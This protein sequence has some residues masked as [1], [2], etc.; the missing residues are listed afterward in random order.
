MSATTEAEFST[1][2]SKA[3]AGQL[4]VD[5][6]HKAIPADPL[7]ARLGVYASLPGIRSSTGLW[8]N[9]QNGAALQYEVQDSGRRYRD[10]VVRFTETG[11]LQRTRRPAAADDQDNPAT[12]TDKSSGFW[13]YAQ[14]PD[15]EPVLD[16]LGL[17]YAVAGGP[18]AK[19]GDHM[20]VLV[21]Q[22]RQLVRVKLVVDRLIDTP[23]SFRATYPAG[24][25]TCSGTSRALRIRLTVAPFGT[26]STDFDFLGLKRRHRRAR[27]NRRVG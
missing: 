10:R 4:V 8:M 1:A 3:I 6:A 9:A 11:A 5:P 14:S 2:A 17:L 20:D 23:V 27:W 7:V 21:F 25:R 13:P 16:S 18:L 12:W 19:A 24:G 15:G 22:R 26:G